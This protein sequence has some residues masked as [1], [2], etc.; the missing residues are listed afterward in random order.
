[1]IAARVKKAIER[2]I[3]ARMERYG[4]RAIAVREGKDH[5][6][7]EV[8][9]V[10]VEYDLVDEPLPLGI[11][12]GLITEVRRVTEPLGEARFPHVRH[13]FDDRQEVVDTR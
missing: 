11:T 1:M 12:Y 2:V 4:M 8:L 7:D 5:D 9:Y 6:G 3:R 10:D 13:H